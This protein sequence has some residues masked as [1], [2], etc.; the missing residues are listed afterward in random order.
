MHEL[1]DLWRH[2]L[3]HW[4]VSNSCGLFR[5]SELY[6]MSGDIRTLNVKN[7]QKYQ[8]NT[9]AQKISIPFSM[10]ICKIEIFTRACETL[11]LLPY[12]WHSGSRIMRVKGFQKGAIGLCSLRG[13]KVTGRQSLK[14]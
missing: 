14:N 4:I 1:A 2:H 12:P 13:C 7:D 6:L 5:M 11:N 3:L 8:E 10:S 9:V